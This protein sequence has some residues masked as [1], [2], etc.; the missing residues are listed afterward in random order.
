[1]PAI[2]CESI[3]R[4]VFEETKSQACER[5]QKKVIFDKYKIAIEICNLV[6]A[7][8]DEFEVESISVEPDQAGTGFFFRVESWNF[9]AN[10]TEGE[11]IRRACDLCNSVSFTAE[12]N[13]VIMSFY[14]PNV[15]EA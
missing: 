7:I 8:C 9:L 1:M 2:K 3:F 14:L 6:D 4:V 10:K 11:C 15:L 13:N 5:T 12:N